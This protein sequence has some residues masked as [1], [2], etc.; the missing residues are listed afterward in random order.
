M[1]MLPYNYD[2]EELDYN[3]VVGP[4]TVVT[5]SY[6]PHCTNGDVSGGCEP[7]AVISAEKLLDYTEGPAETASIANVLNN[8]PKMSPYVIDP[9]AW[10]CIW[11]ELIVNGKGAKTV[12]DRPD[13]P[14]SGS[15]YGFSAEMLDAM[16]VELD[17]L[18]AKYSSS[19]WNTVDTAN[20]LVELV[21]WHRGLIQTEL[22]ELSSGRRKL[23]ANDFLGPKER[24]KRRLASQANAGSNS[25]SNKTPVRKPNMKYFNAR[26]KE[27]MI[28]KRRNARK[29]QRTN[30]RR[31][32]KKV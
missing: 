7:V 6:D 30:A 27:R 12:V 21:T 28:Q 26:A 15:D 5:P 8:N 4:D 13:T 17:R 3:L 29:A 11:N 10:D 24:E 20:R 31:A 19:D 22:D 32:E 25:V 16:L 14:Y 1:L 2:R 23:T 18:I 9:E